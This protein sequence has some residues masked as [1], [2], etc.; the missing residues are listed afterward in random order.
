VPQNDEQRI[1]LLITGW[2]AAVTEWLKEAANED[3]P[4]RLPG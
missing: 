4:D 3:T 2:A 1:R